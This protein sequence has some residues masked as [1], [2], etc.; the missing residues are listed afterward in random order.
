MS[1]KPIPMIEVQGTHREVG[2]QIGTHFRVQIGAS[3]GSMREDLPAGMS[4]EDMLHQS[5]LYLGYSREVYPR[6]IK[7]LQGVA[8]GAGVP[9]DVLFLSMCEELWEASAWRDPAWRARRG[10]TDLA[11][12]GRATVGGSTLIAHTNDLGPASEEELVLLKVKAGDDPEFLGISPGGVGYS[13]GFN[14]AG[15]SIT[16]NELNSNDIRP[17]VPRMLVVRAI[18]AARRLG[19]ALNHCLLPQRAS[20]YNNV[21][22]D[23]HGEVY[24]MEGWPPTVSRSTLRTTCW[25]TPTTTSARPCAASR[26]TATTSAVRSTATTGPSAFCRRT[27]AVCR[28]SCSRLCLPTTPITLP[29]SANTVWTR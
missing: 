24:S 25:P 21:V 14:A 3:L 6:Y 15:V 13:A 20:S 11:A 19:E 10:C 4:W 23:A 5:D 22:A 1:T 7:E 16:G 2:R 27:G 18:L 17:G 9:F 12:R 8:E 28:P 26:P 29:P